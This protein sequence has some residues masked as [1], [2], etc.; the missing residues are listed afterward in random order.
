MILS[1]E[2]KKALRRLQ[3]DKMMKQKELAQQL[4]ITARTLRLITNNNE[5]QKVNMKTYQSIA[6]TIATNY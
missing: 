1:P 2:E 4:G 6:K 5:P 3:A